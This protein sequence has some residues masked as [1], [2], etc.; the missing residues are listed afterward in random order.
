[1]TPDRALLLTL[2]ETLIGNVRRLPGETDP[3]RVLESLM[4][5][6]VGQLGVFQNWADLPAEY[7]NEVQDRIS[8]L[9]AELAA[10][11]ESW[12]Q[13]EPTPHQPLPFQ[14]FRQREPWE[15]FLPQPV[16]DPAKYGLGPPHP[17]PVPAPAPPPSAPP[18]AA[19]SSARPPRPGLGVPIS[20]RPSYGRK[21]S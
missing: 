4:D 7:G 11:H 12:Q 6:A 2:F 13:P 3:D 10:L 21:G 14:Q 8:D 15:D 16:L 19:G 1:M 5:T 18:P 20:V 9:C 17:A